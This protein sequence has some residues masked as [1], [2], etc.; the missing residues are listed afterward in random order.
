M[1]CL[2]QK[3]NEYFIFSFF[4]FGK[5]FNEVVKKRRKLPKIKKVKIILDTM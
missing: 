4:V 1:A 2:K 5:N 3:K